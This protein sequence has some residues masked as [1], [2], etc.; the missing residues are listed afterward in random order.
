MQLEVDSK[1]KGNDMQQI[2]RFILSS[3]LAQLEIG[4]LLT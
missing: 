1:W 2:S 4:T 3:S